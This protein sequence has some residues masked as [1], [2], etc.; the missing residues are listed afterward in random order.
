M[1]HKKYA[2][3]LTLFTT[4]K[5]HDIIIPEQNICSC[6]G[7]IFFC[8]R[9]VKKWATPSIK[10][11]TQTIYK[12]FPEKERCFGMTKIA[13]PV[14]LIAHK[15]Y[16]NPF[17]NC[18]RIFQRYSSE[19][20]TDSKLTA[21]AIKIDSAAFV[22]IF[23][24]IRELLYLC[25][26]YA[27]SLWFWMISKWVFTSRIKPLPLKRVCDGKTPQQQRCAGFCLLSCMTVHGSIWTRYIG[28]IL[29]KGAF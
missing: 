21:E 1:S 10:N 29:E 14:Q 7:M 5:G 13:H 24:A 19:Q 15:Q 4:E 8:S 23:W 26:W 16:I 27:L 3:R 22:S 9:Y 17:G 28:F 12:P 20:R 6:S 25:V 18:L 2:T 11:N